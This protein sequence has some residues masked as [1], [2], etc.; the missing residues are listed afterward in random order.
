MVRQGTVA[1]VGRR[2]RIRSRLVEGPASVGAT[3]R[4]RRWQL[5]HA[6]FPDVEEMSIVDL[7]G[8]VESWA[9]APVRPAHVLVVNV[10][11][12]PP[13]PVSGVDY[14]QADAC[15]LPRQVTTGHFDLA[16]SNSLI[17]HL[18]GHARFQAFADNVHSLALRHWVQTPYR[19][20][21]VE[22]HWLFPGFQ[23]LPVAVRANIYR[24]WP[25]AHTT[26]ADLDGAVRG[27]LNTQLLSLTEM[28]FYF[29]DSQVLFERFGGLVKSLV[30]VG[31]AGSSN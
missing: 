4:R 19:Y 24:W 11:D 27:V 13:D 9:R 23:F 21:P 20:F 8:T 15:S 6:Q 2:R 3:A 16:F 26:P 12:P 31:G 1:D 28:R 25:L 22:P 5:L 7:G 14:I 17:E 18:G 29:P 10:A 30:A